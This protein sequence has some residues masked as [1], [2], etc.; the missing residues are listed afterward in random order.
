MTNRR[1]PFVRAQAFSDR[2][3]PQKVFLNYSSGPLG[4]CHEMAHGPWHDANR[5]FRCGLAV[6]EALSRASA[7]CTMV[8]TFYAHTQRYHRAQRVA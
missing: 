6:R 1:V 3:P 5:L 4:F 2:V 8:Y 7:V